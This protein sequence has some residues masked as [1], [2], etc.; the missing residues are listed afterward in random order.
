[1]R[2]L[3]LAVVLPALLQAQSLEV[4]S[5]RVR[6]DTTTPVFGAKVFVQMAPD[7]ASDSTLTDADGRWQLSFANGTGDYLVRITRVGFKPLKVRVRRGAD[8]SAIALDT[9]LERLGATQQL[10]RVVVNAKRPRPQSTTIFGRGDGGDADDVP[11]GV[12]GA[13]TP[14]LAGNLN[15]LAGTTPGMIAGASGPSAL[16]LDPSQN[17]TRLNGSSFGGGSVPRCAA[18]NT[19]VATSTFDPGRGSFSGAQIDAELQPGFIY[20]SR[21]FSVAAD[22]PPTQL[23]DPVSRVTGAAPT[24]VQACLGAMG[25]LAFERWFYSTSLQVDRRVAD[26][27]DLFSTDASLLGRAGVSSDSASRLFGT[28]RNAG[29]PVAGSIAGTATTDVTFLGRFDHGKPYEGRSQGLVVAASLGQDKGLGL[30]TRDVGS[31]SAQQTRAFGMLQGNATWRFASDWINEFKSSLSWSHQA[32]VP[33]LTL[34]QGRV[35]LGASLADGTTTATSVGFGGSAFANA[36][37]DVVAWETLNETQRVTGQSGAH[38]LKLTAQMRIDALRSMST[39]NGLG[40]FQY[41]SLA[42]LAADRPAS[43]SRTLFAPEARSGQFYGALALGDAWRVTRSLRVQVGA[44]AEVNSW[45]VRAADNPAVTSAFGVRTTDAPNRVHVSPRLGFEWRYGG[46]GGTGITFSNA[47]MWLVMPGGA[48]RGGIGEFRNS[49]ATSLLNDV[50][51]STGLPG[52]AQRVACYGTDVPARDWIGWGSN[53]NT[54]PAACLPGAGLLSDGAPAVQLFS[55][56]YEPQRS[57]R[58]HLEWQTPVPGFMLTVRGTYSVNLNQP[59]GVDLNFVPTEQFALSD[60]AFRPVWVPTGSISPTTG[61]VSPVAARASSAFGPVWMRTSD[62]ESRSKQLL[63]S[64]SPGGFHRLFTRFDYAWNNVQQQFR[65]F[66]GAGAGNPNVVEWARGSNDVR[67]VAQAQLGVSVGPVSLTTRAWAQ[68]GRPFT[69]ML[70]SDITGAGRGG[71]RAFVFSP[72]VV[73]DTAVASGM[74][75]LLAT[76]PTFA[77]NCLLAQLGSVAT[78]NSCEGPWTGGLNVTLLYAGR[79]P[80]FGESSQLRLTAG[81]VLSGI[82][83]LANGSANLQ[84]WGLPIPPDPVLLNVRSFDPVARRYR[85]AVNQRFGSVS[86]LQSLV[87][88]PMTITLDVRL[89]IGVPIPRQQ[90]NRWLRPG[91]GAVPGARISADSL[92]SKYRRALRDVYGGILQETD[93]L[94]LTNTQVAK[95]RERQ[96]LFATRVDSAWRPL[97]DAMATLPDEYDVDEIVRRQEA[98][99]DEVWEM[100]RLDVREW[101]PQLLTPIQLTLLPWPAGYLFASEKRIKGLRIYYY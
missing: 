78:R 56:D 48:I 86:P 24:R 64:L 77:Q 71:E 85:Y 62:L 54:I 18:T 19:R 25:E 40:A 58:G 73:A 57:W 96:H 67:H 93:S 53:P 20:S 55:P 92:L 7:R 97:V 44:R 69:P 80:G 60:E 59:S 52:G 13:L 79:I 82:D 10:E 100:A 43:F 23:N 91:R 5:G 3:V 28:L 84:G 74:R 34:P 76:A 47:A 29:I 6:A 21:S 41:N 36:T 75:A 63:V 99:A 65:G 90:V 50:R 14:D 61:A 26:V 81:N 37:T 4:V 33:D 35:L 51:Q 70:S 11:L 15:A 72:G 1:M 101:L 32:T 30:S 17:Q 31:V 46:N 95:L 27:S 49:L 38:R 8:S 9:A 22:G 83:Q 45:L 68:S 89:D 16:G 42:D 2:S 12:T 66:D 98:V 87:R 88:A 39:D 94:L